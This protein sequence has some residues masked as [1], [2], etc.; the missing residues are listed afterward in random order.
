MSEY[1]VEIDVPEKKSPFFIRPEDKN[2]LDNK[3]KRLFYLGILKERFLADWSPVMWIS[4]E[5]TRDKR[6][7]TDLR[8]LNVRITKNNLA[9]MLLKDT[10]SEQGI[11]SVR[12]KGCIS[13]F[14]DFGKF[15][16]VLWNLTIFWQCF[17]FISE[18]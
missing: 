10:S 4:T 2:I 1:R 18:N 8:N 12:F 6:V 7:V 5:V 9:Y 14:K 17:I 3:M 11:I 15:E 16:K 13:F